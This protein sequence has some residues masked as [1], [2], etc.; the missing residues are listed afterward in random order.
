LL[1]SILT[2]NMTCAV[3]M[4]FLAGHGTLLQILVQQ[5]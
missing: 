2:V 5:K 4:L 1:S 3:V